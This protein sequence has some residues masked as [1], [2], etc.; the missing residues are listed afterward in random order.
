MEEEEQTSW[1]EGE[2]REERKDEEITEEEDIAREAEMTAAER[3]LMNQKQKLIGK[4]GS[5]RGA[6]VYRREG[7]H[8]S[9]KRRKRRKSR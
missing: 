3:K 4:R 8:W 9:E 1:R 5:Q 6:R 7:G 2:V